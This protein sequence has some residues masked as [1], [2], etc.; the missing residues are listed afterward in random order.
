[1]SDYVTNRK[2]RRHRSLAASFKRDERYEEALRLRSER[3]EAYDALPAT[4]KL[5]VGYYAAAKTAAA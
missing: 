3:P 1:L 5:A 2:Q 4:V